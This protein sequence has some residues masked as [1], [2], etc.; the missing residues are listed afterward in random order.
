MLL[1]YFV[2]LSFSMKHI[3]ALYTYLLLFVKRR[4]LFA[5]FFLNINTLFYIK[6]YN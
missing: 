4:T 6:T 1:Y 5:L 2:L 3:Y